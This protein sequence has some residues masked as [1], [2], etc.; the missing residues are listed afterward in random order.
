MIQIDDAGSGSLLGGTIIGAY[1]V[2]T[3]E[4]Y[5][6]VIPLGFYQGEPFQ[7]KEYINYVVE[8]VKKLFDQ[9]RVTKD[10]KIEVCRGYMFEA[11]NKW[12]KEEQYH[13]IN[14][15]IGD[16]LQSAIEKSFDD[17]AIGLGLPK[18]FISYTKYPFHFHR[19]LK[20]VYADY[21]QRSSLCKTGW[22]SWKKYND[23]PIT[24]GEEYIKNKDWICL[25]CNQPIPRHSKAAV[26]SY[27]TNRVY[28]IY[29]HP[30]CT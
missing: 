29:V 23:L 6:D 4:Y 22:K 27:V 16:P 21:Q 28:K 25:K 14:T 19:I 30:Y 10:E 9:L 8:I 24:I 13:F 7:K 5:Y 11:L 2:E 26:K 12:L 15:K 3:D 17:Y 18:E 1:R 20:W